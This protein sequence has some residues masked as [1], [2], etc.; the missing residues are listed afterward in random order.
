[1]LREEA[2]TAE[3]NKR[4]GFVRLDSLSTKM[5]LLG[6]YICGPALW[7]NLFCF[8]FPWVGKDSGACQE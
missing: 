4:S 6:F 7:L 1:M 5:T 2:V 8:F 3:G